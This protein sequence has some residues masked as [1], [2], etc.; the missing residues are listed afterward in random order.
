M[1]TIQDARLEL[2][3]TIGAIVEAHLPQTKG[4]DTEVDIIENHRKKRS[5]ASRESWRPEIGEIRVRFVVRTPASPAPVVD[6]PRPEPQ[7]I[8]LV[9]QDGIQTRQELIGS[10]DRAEHRPG[11]NFVSL[12]WFR[13]KVLPGEGFTWA[14]AYEARSEVLSE[15]IRDNVVLTSK[16]PNP[17]AP[18]FPVTSIRLNRGHPEVISAL[19]DALLGS[20]DFSPV[21][22]RGQALSTTVIQGRR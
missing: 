15:A 9:N 5:D 18:A 22:I 10:L 12:K 11:Y 13:D 2:E 20:D 7:D 1:M 8:G 4:Y 6:T 3:S 17:N 19:G 16:V 14:G 21:E